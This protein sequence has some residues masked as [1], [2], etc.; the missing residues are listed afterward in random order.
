MGTNKTESKTMDSILKAIITL[1]VLAAWLYYLAI[2]IENLKNPFIN[3]CGFYIIE[4]MLHKAVLPMIK[5]Y[6]PKRK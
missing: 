5:H 4:R 3:I 1:S 6:L 2:L